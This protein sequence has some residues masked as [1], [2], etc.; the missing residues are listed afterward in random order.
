MLSLLSHLPQYWTDGAI[1]YLEGLRRGLTEPFPLREDPSPVTPYEVVYE[2]GKVRLRYYR[3]QGE[4]QP[5]PLL[6][7][8]ALIKR[9]YILDLLPGKSVVQSL[10]QQGFNVYLTDWIPPS[11]SDSW[12]GF[13]AYVNGDLANAIRAVEV[14][15]E[16]DQVS[17]LGYCLG[18]LLTTI[19]TALHPEQV[20][21]LL[22]LAVPLDMSAQQ[23]PLFALMNKFSAETVDLITAIYGNCPA[24]FVKAGFSAMSPIHH[25]L[26]KYV[27]LYRSREREDYVRMFD[28]F[29]RWMNSDVPLAGQIFLE[30]T[31]GIFQKNL[32]T[33][34]RLQV[35]GKAV[36]L[37]RITC[38]VLNM[39]GEYDDVVHPTSSL[40][41]P[42]LIGSADKANLLFPAGHI[43]TVVSSGAQKK[44]WPQVGQWLK[45]HA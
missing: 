10:V 32:L 17:L 20:R 6:V 35:G 8:Y 18:G 23:I 22:T 38:P 9:P 28:L 14:R 41:F 7:V 16:T 26:D 29:E 4:P 15:E 27:S 30:V 39:V 31:K 21:N 44:L 5:T 40:P 33:Q 36:D 12:R 13:D 34:N 37:K 45:E 1:R 3:A 11:R 25:G 43:G 2:G 24:W 42:D 19:Y